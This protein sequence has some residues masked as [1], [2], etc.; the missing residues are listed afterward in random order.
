MTQSA[1]LEQTTFTSG[2]VSPALYSRVDL[3]RYTSA[4]RKCLNMFPKA[5][6]GVTKRAGT[7]LVAPTKFTTGGV[8]LLGFQPTTSDTYV[9]ELGDQYMRFHQNGGLILDASSAVTVTSITDA[10]GNAQFNAAG[11]GLAAGQQLFISDNDSVNLLYGR[12]V[13]VASSPNTNDFQ[14]EDW[15]TGTA[16]AYD[17][18]MSSATAVVV[19]KPYE[20]TSPYLAAE[21]GSVS[22]AQS[23]DVLY[24]AHPNHA[25]RKLTRT[26]TTPTFSLEQIFF[27]SRLSPPSTAGV[28]TAWY[29]RGTTTAAAY[30]NNYGTDTYVVTAVDST[31]QTAESLPSN[32][33]EAFRDALW[34]DTT[35]Q[36]EIH[37]GN[38]NA[39]S[40]VSGSDGFNVYKR[41]GGV[42]LFIGS[43]ENTIFKDPNLTPAVGALSPPE[44][45]DFFAIDITYSGGVGGI[46]PGDGQTVTGS[47][48]GATGRIISSK[49]A[50][51][52]SGTI[53]VTPLTGTFTEADTIS[54][55]TM[56]TTTPPNIDTIANNYPSTVT[57]F[58]DRL[59][60]AASDANPQ[61][62]WTSQ[63]GDY[64]NITK[65][66]VPVASDALEFTIN[67]RQLNRVYHMAP[68]DALILMTSGSVWAA[69]GAG[70]NSP[71]APD[72]LKVKVQSYNGSENVEPLFF[73]DSIVF[74]E[75]KA[76][77][78]RDLHYE[79]TSDRYSGND[80]SV[81][82]R[83]LFDGYTISD[84]C[85]QK[86]P[87]GLIWAAR[88]DGKVLS[89]TYLR[90]H[91]VRGWAQHTIGDAVTSMAAVSGSTE[92]DVYMVVERGS[93]RHVEVMQSRLY[94][95]D[96]EDA[97]FVDDG[98]TGSIY[99]GKTVFGL[100]HLEG[101]TLS[102]LVDGNVED[103]L[104][105]A[106]GQITLTNAPT[107]KV[108]IGVPFTAEMTTLDINSGSNGGSLQAQRRK[109]ARIFIRVSN[110]RGVFGA[111][112]GVSPLNEFKEQLYIPDAP[113]DAK[114]EVIEVSPSSEW[115]RQGR[116]HL[117]FPYPLPAEVLSIMPEM[118][119]GS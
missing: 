49:D 26:A 56:G 1:I 78:I 21:V 40:L 17:A 45:N 96:I 10:S 13:K 12:F 27:N 35:A 14:L 34:A 77:T 19:T 62:V 106:N 112:D 51:T 105:V 103:G 5:E 79:F 46:G 83:H 75:N 30:P 109:V 93:R 92:D 113:I 9:I 116:V 114:S 104:V 81:M 23:V 119:V 102:A 39:G 52:A 84:W 110:T 68:L 67:S 91:D 99:S 118:V 50:T 47:P 97:W 37:I 48:S 6:G 64:E 61:T 98:V 20:I 74:V 18:T 73:D 66:Q 117:E 100:W 115:N 53:K 57:F 85:L 76:Q 95:S 69:T 32:E 90:E 86:V 111:E 28:I 71:I 72:S 55:A 87:F 43:T 59:C 11:H 108:I 7:A 25:P 89:L 16:V 2:E 22:A 36:S 82:S 33:I 15:E 65:S 41:V 107:S 31:G 70:E 24:L 3:Q 80:L 8:R 63:S 88:S 60:W 38:I 42:F 54:S 101:Q 29:N 4:L 44:E 94:G 58:E